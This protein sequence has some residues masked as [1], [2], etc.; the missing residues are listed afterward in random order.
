M[1]QSDTKRRPRKAK[2]N[3]SL[4]L[5]RAITQ[6]MAGAIPGISDDTRDTVEDSLA[7]VGGGLA[8][9]AMGEDEDG[10]LVFPP[11]HNLQRSWNADSR[12]KAGLPRQPQV[13]PGI[14]EDTLSTPELGGLIGAP[15]PQFS[16][17]AGEQAS[18]IHSGVN[19][20]MGLDAPE[21]FRQNAMDS[22]GIMAGQL[23]I[24]GKAKV[25]AAQTMGKGALN[26]MK[27]YGSKIAKSP[28]EFF[29]PT[30]DPK[31]SNYG[32]GALFGGAMGSAAENGGGIARFL[33]AM[34]NQPAPRDPRMPNWDPN[35]QSQLEDLNYEDLPEVSMNAKGGKVGALKQML[36]AINLNPDSTATKR[37]P[38]QIGEPVEEVLY[39]VNEGTRRGVLSSNEAKQIKAMLEAGDD[40]N[41]ADAL[42]DLHQRLQPQI[43]AP[44][45]T[46]PP[47]IKRG[48][49][50]EDPHERLDREQIPYPLLAP[51]PDDSARGRLTP[52]EF[53]RLVLKKAKG[54]KVGK[55]KAASK[56]GQDLLRLLTEYMDSPET[57]RKMVVD[58]DGNID[59]AKA[60]RE[61]ASGEGFARDTEDELDET[62]LGDLEPDELQKAVVKKVIGKPRRG[63]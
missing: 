58:K 25:E 41:L 3:H 24:P 5:L 38:Y 34:G 57:A 33:E 30:V 32:A 22:L 26:M 7:R 55:V 18:R 52:E 14:V 42:L 40:E 63:K 1:P 45:P 9:Q 49:I 10:N 20:S 36:K 62:G 50:R 61:I 31:L 43:P 12:R 46:P 39:A 16:E 13:M 8:S 48:G 27:H 53:D 17:D 28:V 47:L 51:V 54:G 6:S 19:E 15:V 44:R 4:E 59:V 37:I 23:P 2:K 21:G 35:P 60:K 56:L 29:S 11:L